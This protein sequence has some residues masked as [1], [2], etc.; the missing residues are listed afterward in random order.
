MSHDSVCKISISRLFISRVKSAKFAVIGR[1]RGHNFWDGQN[2]GPSEK[3][4][5]ADYRGFFRHVRTRLQTT[6]C[7]YF[8]AWVRR[9]AENTRESRRAETGARKNQRRVSSFRARAFAIVFRGSTNSRGKIGTAR[10]LRFVQHKTK[11][12]CWLCLKFIELPNRIILSTKVKLTIFFC[13]GYRKPLECVIWW[14]IVDMVCFGPKVGERGPTFPL[15]CV[16]QFYGL[17][18]TLKWNL[19]RS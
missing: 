12:T 16:S 2:L 9:A 19:K 13:V 7:P 6:S 17:R 11:Q 15:S 4:G 18:N 14:K 5:I 10:S 8:S 1:S 3:I